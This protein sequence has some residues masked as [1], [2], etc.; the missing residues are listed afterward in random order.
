M[1]TAHK[2]KLTDSVT[3]QP[4][5][6]QIHLYYPKIVNLFTCRDPYIKQEVCIVHFV[7]YPDIG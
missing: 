1:Y 2:P 6:L 3:M 5:T 7:L 4:A